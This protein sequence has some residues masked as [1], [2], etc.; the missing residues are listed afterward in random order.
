MKYMPSNKQLLPYVAT[1]IPDAESEVNLR[2]LA[3]M[4]LA[5]C[6]AS[7]VEN[8]EENAEFYLLRKEFVRPGGEI[9][10]LFTIAIEEAKIDIESELRAIETSVMRMIFVIDSNLKDNFTF[11]KM[12]ETDKGVACREILRSVGHGVSFWDDYDPE[13]FG[14]SDRPNVGWFESPHNEC[15]DVL[16]KLVIHIQQQLA[17]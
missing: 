15:Y 14:Q 6:V 8:S 4:L 9:C 10:E 5:D 13:D 16:T 17:A 12:W 7:E 1:G 2:E 11:A 3:I